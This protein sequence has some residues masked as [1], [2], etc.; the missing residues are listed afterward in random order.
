ML[1][2]AAIQKEVAF[3]AYS[4]GTFLVF[5]Y[6]CKQTHTNYEEEYTFTAKFAMHTIA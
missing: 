5:G 2:C 3:N 4:L 1:I 6:I